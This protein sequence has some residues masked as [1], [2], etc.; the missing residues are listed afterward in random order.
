V[1]FAATCLGAIPLLLW[2][3]RGAWFTLDEWDLV[4]L[5]T[6]G[7][8]G[9]LFRPHYQHW[10]TLPI[11]EFRVLFQV[12]GLR[13]YV[14]YQLL[15]ILMH[16]AAAALLFVVMRRAQVFPWLATVYAGAF[17]LFGSGASDMLNAFQISFVGALVFGLVQLIFADHDGPIDRRDWVGLLFGLLALMCSGIA[18]TMVIVV[19][20][21]TL[22]RRNWRVAVFHTVPLGVV[23]LVWFAIIG[24]NQNQHLPIEH[25]TVSEVLRFVA[26]GLRAAL[27]DLGQVPVVPVALAVVLVGGIY[28]AYR[29]LGREDFRRRAAAPVSLLAGSIVFLFLTG[30][31]RA[32]HSKFA[33]IATSGPEYARES[34]YVYLTAAM[35]LP[36]LAFASTALL[37]RSRVLGVFVIVLPLL[38]V[39][40]NLHAFNEFRNTFV[41]LPGI[42]ERILL[43]PRTPLARQLPRSTEPDGFH[44]PG[45]TIG[46]LLD[47]TKAGKI[48]APDRA[49]PKAVATEA[50]HIA[51]ITVDR[52]PGSACTSVSGRVVR[53][54]R[55]GQ[56]VGFATPSVEVEYRSPQ[57]IWSSPITFRHTVLNPNQTVVHA[58]AGPLPLR[59]AAPPGTV[60]CG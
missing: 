34:R 8:L 36:A 11:I 14:P 30:T 52:A 21:A 13:T 10:F 53:T 29:Q 12:F 18:V 39:P 1:V 54:L 35:M 19:G 20:I 57:G 44:A 50:L 15:S 31:G 4:A 37:R 56:S 5:R 42:R 3:G 48:P 32:G 51:L 38:G 28:V 23:Y 26:V 22:L 46:W 33:F 49:T 45:L 7:N 16:I 43:A 41:G 2:Y 58:L 17:V 59:I 47:S 25:P 55:R 27:G 40:G 6:A 24:H 9:D 60:M